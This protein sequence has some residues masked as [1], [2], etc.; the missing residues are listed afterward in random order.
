MF[1]HLLRPVRRLFIAA[2]ALLLPA[3]AAAQFQIINPQPLPLDE[4]PSWA[5]AELGFNT[6]LFNS[7][8]LLTLS[9]EASFFN[10][11]LYRVGTSQTSNPSIG[12]TFAAGGVVTYDYSVPYKVTLLAPEV[13][14]PGR[15]YT[16]TPYL[17]LAGTP[18]FSVAQNL[19]YGTF[20]DFALEVPLPLLPD[21]EVD[22]DWA[23]P[24]FSA[25]GVTI[26]ATGSGTI[27]TTGTTLTDRAE[28]W[29]P[30]YF[31]LETDTQSMNAWS[32]SVDLISLA[33]RFGVPLMGTIDTLGF[34]L[35]LGLGMPIYRDD[36]LGMLG[37]ALTDYTFEV[38]NDFAGSSFDFQFSS[39][40]D[41]D[42]LFQSRYDYGGQIT[43]D[44]DG[45]FFDPLNVLTMN[46]GTF[47]VANINNLFEG[48]RSVSVSGSIA[49]GDP[50][51]CRE[52]LGRV[53]CYDPTPRLLEP[54]PLSAF[55]P[56]SATIV[57]DEFADVCDLACRFSVGERALT[58][59]AYAPSDVAG[60]EDL[61]RSVPEPSGLALFAL[62]LFSLGAACRLRPAFRR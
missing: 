17:E 45:P 14:V 6:R 22:V 48:T 54:A 16:V 37:Y 10:N 57:S 53:V 46:L 28:S 30:G 20:F 3:V 36:A 60:F 11:V 56:V 62:A 61:V 50:S 31:T 2:V 9:G 26:D 13:V 49:V 32:A 8:S 4:H 47:D 23:I 41:Y 12:L 5:P 38:P 51:Q 34:D 40:L 27:N 19:L 25:G 15:S 21:I 58:D 55:P 29:G 7:S 24:D 1:E 59:V 42:L 43:L 18:T 52:Q 44:F 39:L 33:S 35:D